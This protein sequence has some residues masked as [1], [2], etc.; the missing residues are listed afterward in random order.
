[1]NLKQM[2]KNE[3]EKDNTLATKLANMAGF[4]NSSPLYKFVNEEDREMESFQG[5]LSIIRHLSPDNEFEVMESYLLTVDPNKKTARYA[6]EYASINGLRELRDRLLNLY[7]ANCN[8]KESIEWLKL[9]NYESKVI[10]EPSIR[11]MQEVCSLKTKHP[12]TSAFKIVLG[13][14]NAYGAQDFKLLKELSDYA[15]PLIEN[16]K[17]DYIRDCFTSRLNLL[18]CASNVYRGNLEEARKTGKT[19]L[20]ASWSN[21]VSSL[22]CLNLGNA[23]I[24]ES[25]D[26]A[27]DYL[28][29][30]LSY[31]DNAHSIA[32]TKRSLSFLHSFWGKDNPYV[33]T[34]SNRIDDVLDVAFYCISKGQHQ[35]AKIVFQIE[36]LDKSMMDD[37]QVAYYLYLQYRLNKN[38]DD[39]FDSIKAFRKVGDLLYLKLTLIELAKLG[40]DPNILDVMGA[41]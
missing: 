41:S 11:L 14:Y 16:I 18:L 2:I 40:V 21:R 33:N 7:E 36:K 35:L 22:I 38:L 3:L 12:E 23:Y 6:L 24:F 27:N 37:H 20:L 30:A 1:M 31:S 34:E 8:N 10:A 32:E 4:K 5:L 29:K 17:D 28:Q 25:F 15:T 26:K 9:Y 13:A 39:L 19:G